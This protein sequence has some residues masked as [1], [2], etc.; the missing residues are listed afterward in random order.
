MNDTPCA[1]EVWDYPYLWAWQDARDETEGRKNRPSAVVVTLRRHDGRTAIYLLAVTS[2]MPG[3]GRAVLEIP[4]TERHRAGLS[5]DKRLWVVL[6]EF[7]SD[8]YENSYYMEPKAQIGTFGDAFLKQI[9][10]RFRE[11]VRQRKSKG[12]RRFDD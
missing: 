3:N 5:R 1:G 4:E 8:V 7:N 9:Q 11:I 12:I 6:D 2:K 10:Q